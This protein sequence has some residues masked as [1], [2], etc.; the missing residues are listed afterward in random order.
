MLA[1]GHLLVAVRSGRGRSQA[2]VSKVRFADKLEPTTDASPI[3]V[4]PSLYIPLPATFQRCVLTNLLASSN[5][6]QSNSD[7][8]SDRSFKGTN[9]SHLEAAAPP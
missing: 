4:L 6:A 5:L 1:T 8:V 2:L 7:D 3:S 9:P